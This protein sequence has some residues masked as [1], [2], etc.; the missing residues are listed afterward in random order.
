MPENVLLSLISVLVALLSGERIY[1]RIKEQRLHN[2]ISDPGNDSGSSIPL[3]LDNLTHSVNGLI[4]TVSD[5]NSKVERHL[6][7][8]EGQR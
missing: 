4:S 7:F 2:A 5:L 1:A 8:H 3:R 6:G